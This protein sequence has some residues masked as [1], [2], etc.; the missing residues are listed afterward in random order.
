MHKLNV[1]VDTSPLD[2]DHAYRGIG[3]YTRL[4][5]EHLRAIPDIKVIHTSQED[6][7]IV[8]PDVVHYPYFDLFFATLPLTH[9]APAV[10]TIH[11]VIPLLFPKAY[12]PGVKGRL[13]LQRQK[14]AL[15][16]AK[17][18]ITD[19]EASKQDII[20]K[21]GVAAEKVHVI[22]LAANPQ[23]EK[24]RPETIAKVRRQ[25]QLPTQYL[26][27]V[28]DINYN[29]NIPQL[30]K[31][32]KY[33]PDDL[34]LVLVGRNFKPQ[35]IPE[36]QWIETQ[37]AMSNVEPRIHFIND[38][39]PDQPEILSALYTGALAYIQPSLYEGF[40]LPVLE[41]MQCRTPVI[42]SQNSSL[43]EV[44]GEHVL[45]TEPEAEAI[46]EHIKNILEWTDSRRDSW[47]RDAYNWSHT[48]SWQKTAEQTA[49]VY[50]SVSKV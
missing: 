32:L 45:Y 44:G 48:F 24:A 26:L 2:N 12:R 3:M 31:T 47:L 14:L 18:I 11:D 42:S 40:G 50:R 8:K 19:S 25:Y 37:I 27:Y 5:I 43:T 10:V 35:D 33:L 34:H 22:Y 16:K 7:G 17:A 38:L 6:H 29:K 39:P 49:A 30:I 21:L 4:L 13:R 1:V 28:G 9:P 20:K 36:W 15:H 23:L 46:A 41:A